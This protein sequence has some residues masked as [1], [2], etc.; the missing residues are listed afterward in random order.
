MA[1]SVRTWAGPR[2][3]EGMEQ[4]KLTKPQTGLDR[5]SEIPLD[6]KGLFPGDKVRVRWNSL[7]R[8][9]VAQS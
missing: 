4:V 3:Q 2:L 8:E 1:D 9:G 5:R 6:K 7:P